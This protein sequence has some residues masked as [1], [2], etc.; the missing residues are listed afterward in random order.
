MKLDF[1]IL[2]PGL[3]FNGETL[4]KHSLGGSET[5][6]ICLAKALVKLGH[7][8]SIFCNTDAPGVWD[9]VK[10]IN[11]AYWNEF[12]IKNPHT[13][14]IVQRTPDAFRLTGASKLNYLWCHDLALRR[15]SHMFR[16]VLWNVDR[17]VVLSDF[18]KDQYK[19]VYGVTDELLFQTRNGVDFDL[20][21]SVPE[22]KRDMNSI[23]YAARP[24]RG[25]DVLLKEIFPRMKAINPN[26][27]LSICTYLNPVGLPEEFTAEIANLCRE[28]GVNDLGHLAKVDLYREMKSHGLYVYPTPSPTSPEFAEVSC[29]AAIEAQACGL[30][31]VCT[32]KG[33][34]GETAPGAVLIEQGDG[35]EG[36]FATAASLLMQEGELKRWVDLSESGAKHVRGVN[37]W[38]TIAQGWV[39]QVMIDLELRS[40]NKETLAAWFYKRSDIEAARET[41]WPIENLNPL[42]DKI[43]NEIATHYSFTNSPEAYKAQYEEMGKDSDDNL[44][45]NEAAGHFTKEFILG[46]TQP[47][48]QMFKKIIGDLGS[49]PLSILDYG[50][51]HGWSP[52]FIAGNFPQHRVTGYDMDRSAIEWCN[53]FRDRIPTDNEPKFTQDFSEVGIDYD[54]IVCSEVLEHVINWQDEL[55][56]LEMRAKPGAMVIITVPM[57]PWEFCGPNW[58]GKRAHI[59]EFTLTDIRTAF[60][61]KPS[62][63]IQASTEKLHEVT[64]EPCGFYLITY[65]ADQKRCLP[66]DFDTK[67]KTQA[68]RQSLSVNIIAGA[69]GVEDTL[70]WCL[71]SVKYIADEIIIGDNGMSDNALKIAADF[72]CKV[73]KVPNPIDIGFD[74]SRNAVLEASSGDWIFWIDT[75]ERL[76]EPFHIMKYLR[77]NFFHGYSVKQVHVDVDGTGQTDYPVRLFRRRPE[78]KFYGSVHEHPAEYPGNAGPGMIMMVDDV[79]LMHIGY[80]NEHTRMQRFRRNRPLL[81]LDLKNNPD[82]LLNKFLLMRDLTIENQN[83][84]K[85]NGQKI[86]A[87][88]KEKAQRVVDLYR[89]HFLDGQ[90]LFGIDPRP[91]YAMA[92]EVLDI[93]FN[94]SIEIKVSRNGVGD[95]PQGCFR[96]AN[97]ADF[98]REVDRIYKSKVKSVEG[99]YW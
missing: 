97:E 39:D 3:P 61:G 55:L 77:H 42:G 72:G 89:E 79:R 34:L 30:P 53:T 80:T 21:D 38:D 98:K 43:Y 51:G 68:P 71:N 88:M 18:M 5:A 24:E 63:D 99:A 22:Q 81:E 4:S 6:G 75:D 59:R 46:N 19:E 17:V 1:Q 83:E 29:I 86:T 76:V 28:H 85:S 23:L 31:I 60:K 11:A 52:L 35:F 66:F 64:G 58:Y 45:K 93:G 94:A 7:N 41:L 74:A 78:V 44:A 73:I 92:C 70:R 47:R 8:A 84:F 54:V 13:V 96:F 15:Y 36:R 9:G 20:I 49:E 16:S 65:L 27:K 87:G 14:S 82:R 10:Y 25:L 12:A 91:Q 2:V 33:A 32:N 69:N 48:F 95:N 90:D 26:L 67:I 62:L 37:S 57:G 40:T 56:K 50:C